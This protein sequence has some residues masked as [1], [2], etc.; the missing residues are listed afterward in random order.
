MA[1]TNRHFLSGYVW[2]ITHRCHKKEFLLKLVKDRQR[3][4][5]LMF[6]AKKRYGLYI[7][8]YIIKWYMNNGVG[9]R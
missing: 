4:I 5:Y 7:L 9:P 2:H 1:R 3:L 8:N 6:E